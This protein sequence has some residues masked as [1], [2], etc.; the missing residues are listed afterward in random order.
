MSRQNPHYPLSITLPHP[1]SL[2]IGVLGGQ[3][4]I[5][6]GDEQSLAALARQMDVD[7]LVTGGT[8]KYGL[9]SPLLPCA[10]T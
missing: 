3:Q 7:V 5:P 9:L 1:P 8:H 6:P 10:A 2:R 4:V